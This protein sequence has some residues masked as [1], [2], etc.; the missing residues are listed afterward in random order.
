MNGKATICVF[1][2]NTPFENQKQYPFEQN[3]FVNRGE[4]LTAKPP[5]IACADKAIN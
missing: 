5:R 3:L 4:D 2:A 1:N